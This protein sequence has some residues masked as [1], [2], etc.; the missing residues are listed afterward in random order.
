MSLIDQ[1]VRIYHE[2]KLWS[3]SVLSKEESIEYYKEILKKGKLIYHLQ[4]DN[5]VGFIEWHN[6]NDDQFVRFIHNKEF[7][8]AEEDIDSGS[9]CYITSVWVKNGHR[10]VYRIL[11]DRLLETNKACELFA[12]KELKRNNRLRMFRR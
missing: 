11:R 8:I 6:L 4:N 5:I 7:H 10:Y 12:G 9:I 1:L 3:K 2:E